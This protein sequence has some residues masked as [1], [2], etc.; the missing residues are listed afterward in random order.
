MISIGLTT[1][2]LESLI[3]KVEEKVRTKQTKI[4][5]P[6]PKPAY[7]IESAEASQMVIIFPD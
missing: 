7:K 2:S 3:N 4:V 5:L 1:K 6:I